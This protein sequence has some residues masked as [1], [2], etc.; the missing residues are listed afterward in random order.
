MS[1]QDIIQAPFELTYQAAA[2]ANVV[3]KAAPGF[4]HEIIVGGDV[5]GGT[6][7][8]SDHVSDGDGNIVIKLIDPAVGVYLVDAMF[9]AGITADITG[10]Q[11][12]VTFVWR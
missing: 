3:V 9:T 7:E 4:L 5:S 12:N 1:V 8:V 11:T 2:A 10:A 6:I